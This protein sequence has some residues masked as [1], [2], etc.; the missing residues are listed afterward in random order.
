[1]VRLAEIWRHPIKSHGRE[2]LQSAALSAGEVI[3]GDRQWAVA[4]EAAKLSDGWNP[5][6]HFSRGGKAP[7]LMALT[8]RYDEAAGTVTL[9][10]PDKAPLTFDPDT[11][12]D[13]FLDWVAPLMPPDR[14]ASKSIVRIGTRGMTDTPFPSISLANPAT[15]KAV[16]DAVGQTL[17][18]H[19]WRANLWV[20]GIAAWEE[21]T[22]IGRD[23]SIG[24][25]TFAVRERITRC[26]AT[27]ANP[28]TGKID[29]DTLGTLNGTF[30]HQDFGIYLECTDAG[31][32]AVGDRV[33]LLP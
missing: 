6:V 32:I 9:H 16:S 28:D 26:R 22:W 17:S 14:A 3:P 31:A 2:A 21:F 20:E 15:N 19:R 23:L 30:G 27:M 12:S 7:G 13:V 18:H 5:C 10:H 11:E 4:H 24:E 25:A 29:A 8:S 1:M 33:E